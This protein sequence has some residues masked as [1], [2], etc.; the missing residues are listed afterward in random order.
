MQ[1]GMRL[2]S[3]ATTDFNWLYNFMNECRQ[4]NYRV[5]Y[6]VVHAYWGGLSATEWYQKLKVIHQRT[7]RP[8]WIKKWN[9]GA[10]WT[11]ESWPSSQ[12]E[13]YAK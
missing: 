12:N 9:N 2:G 8:L 4:R 1:T 7:K 13:Q 3:P 10:N 5:D 6:V 11:K